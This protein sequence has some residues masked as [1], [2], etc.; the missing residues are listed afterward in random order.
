MIG[1]RSLRES[2]R[3]LVRFV[4]IVR[5]VVAESIG[6]LLTRDSVP[7]RVHR[8]VVQLGPTFIK[9]G[10]IASTRPD[11][12]PADVSARLEDLQ[13]HVP[14]FPFEDAQTMVETE[15]ERPLG[16]AFSEFPREPIASASL[17]QVYFATLPD[18]TPV[19]VKV[20][21]PGI[22]TRIERDLRILRR[23]ARVVTWLGVVPRTLRL[24]VAVNEFA[25]W[26]LKE[27]DFEVEGQNLD[28]FSENFADWDDVTF[29]TVYWTHTTSQILTMERV[30]GLRLR[31]VSEH[32]SEERR[33][34]IAKRLSELQMKM[35]I[36]DSFFHA[37]L[38]P[39]NIFF[40]PNG[41]LAI[42][43]VGM[44]GRMTPEQ[45][46]RFLAYWIAISRRQRDRAFHHLVAMAESTKGAD[47]AAYRHAYDEH[48]DQFYDRDLAERSLA[49][50]Y[51]EIVLSGARHGVAFPSEM[52]L[53]A[54]AVVTAEALTLVLAPDYRF[55]DEVRP[56]VAREM[57]NLSTSQHVI[58]RAWGE[59]VDWILLGDGGPIDDVPSTNLP[60][61][62]DFR[63]EA[64]QALVDVWADDL[65]DHLRDIQA[66]VPEYTSAE[67]WDA[68]PE[69]H[70]LL[71]TGLGLLRILAMEARRVEQKA[72]LNEAETARVGMGVLADGAPESRLWTEQLVAMTEV[73]ED[74][75]QDYTSPEF[76]DQNQEMRA[77]LISAITLL[78]LLISRVNRAVDD[79]YENEPNPF[80]DTG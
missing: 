57:A 76:W 12:V 43:D 79:R 65:D 45:R 13:E 44:V 7:D 28:E 24:E 61:E 8:A 34:R 31:E 71:E 72:E 46:D 22:R 75:T 48:L 40:Q 49:Q 29:P 5:I 56:I 23:L 68:H 30:D 25:T 62:A 70:T 33:Q 21:R 15:L 16:E 50:T 36:T 58:D 35:F 60:D 6:Y 64:I 42:L 55:T 47:L 41:S 19:A 17:S 14:P 77:A 11:L 66:D 4:E 73:L 26:T 37:D 1:V 69:Y 53:Q 78:R 10:Q 39:G 51:L 80:A 20:Q 2:Y 9:L 63:R 27:L 59:L 18:G 74:E 3:T 67:Y 32:V 52:I 38:H 54:K